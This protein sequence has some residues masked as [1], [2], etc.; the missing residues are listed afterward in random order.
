MI[1]K[2]RRRPTLPLADRSNRR[3]LE[4]MSHLPR[5]SSASHFRTAID[6]AGRSFAGK[7]PTLR[8]FGPAAYLEY[9][10]E[11]AAHLILRRVP[12]PDPSR[13]PHRS[14]YPDPRP[15]VTFGVAG[16]WASGTDEAFVAARGLAHPLPDYTIHLGDVYF[17]GDRA[18]IDTNFL[19]RQSRRYRYAYQTVKWPI[20]LRGAFALNGNHEMYA[21][22]HAYFNHLL[23][24]IGLI[25]P[26]PANANSHNHRNQPTPHPRTLGQGCSFF[27]LELDRWLIVAVDTGYNSRGLPF[28][29]QLD[30]FYTPW[31]RRIQNALKPS[32]S[33]PGPLFHWLHDEVRP[34]IHAD[35][36][37]PPRGVIL[38][39]HHQPFSAFPDEFAFETP[40]AQI[41]NALGIDTAIWFW[42]HEHRLAGYDLGG[43]GPLKVHGRCLGH[44]GMPVA[45]VAQV[46]TPNV[47][48]PPII[49]TGT[50]PL[51]FL[52]NRAYQTNPDG[53][54]FGWN[55]Y[56]KL[57]ITGDTVSARYFDIASILAPGACDEF[58]EIDDQDK[59]LLEE[60]FTL[61]PT[62]AI[63]CHTTQHNL[64]P[65][66]YGPAKWG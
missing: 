48:L 3:P 30:P 14:I 13:A 26:P 8:N 62:G 55:G 49:A 6:K 33:L 34:L 7:F 47:P 19:G 53:S 1:K 4:S 36:A 60:M 56:L 20:G 24:A 43:I 57:S 16:D 23:P 59:L 40:A 12:F 42:G 28:I 45:T 9:I 32:C 10:R 22:G 37:S 18:E 39:S 51:R 64:E 50:P 29:S 61:A 21:N 63:A 35:P 5:A 2:R 17:V 31:L 44:G 25:D 11:Y 15:T 66:L 46:P 54:V 38:L 27:C 65:N 58:A 41:H 52:D